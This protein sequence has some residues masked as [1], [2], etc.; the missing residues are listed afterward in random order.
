LTRSAAGPALSGAPVRGVLFDYGNT[1][2][3][4]TRPD[5]ELRAA[6]DR[7]A[8]LLHERGLGSPLAADLLSDVHRRVEDE[9]ITHQ[10]SGAL[11]EID[12]VAAARRAYA[13]FGLTLEEE[14][15]DEI[16][17]LE[18]ES[19]WQGARVDPDAVPVIEQLRGAGIRVGLCSNAPYRVRSMH[20]QLA[21][22]GLASHLDSVTF[23]G[24]LGWRKPSPRIFEHALLALG[25]NAATT[26]MVGDTER[27]DIEGAHATGMRAVLLR[28]HSAAYVGNHKSVADVIIRRL[29]EI[30]RLLS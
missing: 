9:F 2:V 22:V 23:S 20:E 10:R 16:L 25:T 14:V 13:D 28:N 4:F 24:E 30:P 12:L 18:Q 8:L 29:A 21:Y 3:A 19:W 17:R 1:L 5:A 27:D 6:Y 15:L 7:I 26:V 11:E